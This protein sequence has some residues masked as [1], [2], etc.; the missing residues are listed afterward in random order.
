M[1]L[2]SVVGV[3]MVKRVYNYRT[4]LSSGTADAELKC[5]CAGNP[6]LSKVPSVKHVH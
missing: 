3:V 4:V 1:G 2:G 6:K 5:P